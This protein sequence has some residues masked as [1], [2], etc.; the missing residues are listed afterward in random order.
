MTNICIVDGCESSKKVR[1]SGPDGKV[2][3]IRN[4]KTVF[5]LPKNIEL[6]HQWVESIPNI[7]GTVT[8]N[9]GVCIDHFKPGDYVKHNKKITLNSNAVPSLFNG[10]IRRKSSE[11]RENEKIRD[12]IDKSIKSFKEEKDLRAFSDFEE[13]KR[14]LHLVNNSSFIISYDNNSI[15]FYKVEISS[16]RISQFLKINKDLSVSSNSSISS[17][18][19]R[20]ISQIS[21]LLNTIVSSQTSIKFIKNQIIQSLENF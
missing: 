19:V 13:L 15:L 14:K 20:S 2:K 4:Y 16:V 1:V 8:D 18:K 5:S 11:Q 17:E 12:A 10:V 7:K 9:K 21:D 3:Y 6:H